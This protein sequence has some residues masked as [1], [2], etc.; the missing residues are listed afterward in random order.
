MVLLALILT[1]IRMLSLLTLLLRCV[2][3]YVAAAAS[4][5]ILEGVTT[6]VSQHTLVYTRLTGDPF[7][8]SARRAKALKDAGARSRRRLKSEPPSRSLMDIQSICF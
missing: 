8:V 4:V 1:L 7:F 3:F 6:S 2:P 5:R